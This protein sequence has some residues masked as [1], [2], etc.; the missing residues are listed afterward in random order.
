LRTT[1]SDRADHLHAA[2][3]D[4]L[5]ELDHVA[6][7]LDVGELLRVR[8]RGHVVDRCE[9]EQV[10][11]VAA[12]ALD[13]LVRDSEPRL[14]EVADDRHHPPRVVSPAAAELLEP[15]AGALAHEHVDR[16]LAGEQELDQVSTDEPRRSGY[17]VAH[18]SSSS[19]RP[20]AYP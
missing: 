1:A 8:I 9:V 19:V 12:Q 20:T 13:V 4:R 17:E 7:A 3:L 5:R 10:I 16:A 18:D 2:R 14:R 6:G 15:A 11:D